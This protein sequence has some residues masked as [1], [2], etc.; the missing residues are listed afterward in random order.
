M[1]MLV[2]ILQL[3][4]HPAVPVHFQHGTAFYNLHEWQATERGLFR[5]AAV[6]EERSALGEI[7][8][9]ARRIGQVP[10]VNDFAFEV[11]EIN[12]FVFHKMRSKKSKSR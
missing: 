10:R 12:D 6:V 1:M 3:P 11:D 2:R 5:S 7:A 8:G 4:K 9:Q